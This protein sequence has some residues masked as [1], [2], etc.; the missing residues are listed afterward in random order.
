MHQ[1]FLNPEQLRRCLTALYTH[2]DHQHRQVGLPEHAARTRLYAD[3]FTDV[4]A[5]QGGSG[6]RSSLS[7][8][9]WIPQC[10]ALHGLGVLTLPSNTKQMSTGGLALLDRIEARWGRRPFSKSLR[11]IVASYQENWDGGGHPYQ[12]RHTAIPLAARIAAIVETYTQAVP[13]ASDATSSRHFDAID[14]LYCHR[15]QRFDPE[16]VEIFASTSKQLLRI[17]ERPMAPARGVPQDCFA[18]AVFT[19]RIRAPLKRRPSSHGAQRLQW[20]PIA[21][22][23]RD[24]HANLPR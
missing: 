3:V 23:N 21:N 6:V 11:H 16:L 15:G 2:R 24:G 5:R 13:L 22:P 17:S 1:N 4:I 20:S 7:Q 18:P 19:R 12:L 9:F 14:Y 8:M 10:I